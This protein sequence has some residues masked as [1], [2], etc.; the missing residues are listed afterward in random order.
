[1][2]AGL[3][4]RVDI[5]LPSLQ[6]LQQSITVTESIFVA[7]EE[8]K[9]S[10]YLVQP[11]E[12]LKAAGALQDLSRYVQTLPGVVI[13]SDDF[14]NDIIVRGGSPLENLFIVDNIVNP[15]STRSRTSHQR[16]AP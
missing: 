15:I 14:R 9:N 10:S 5:V 8:V 12:I 2:R 13:G 3:D 4:H 7:P 16:A 6:G 1:M 11:R